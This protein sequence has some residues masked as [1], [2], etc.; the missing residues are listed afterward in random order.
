MLTVDEMNSTQCSR[1]H[2][3]W[4]ERYRTSIGTPRIALRL[5][6]DSLAQ[7]YLQE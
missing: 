4:E 2:D 6:S 7:F 5:V 3:Q 1:E